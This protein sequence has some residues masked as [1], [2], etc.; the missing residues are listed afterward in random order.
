MADSPA[1]A[2]ESALG[3]EFSDPDLLVEALTHRSLSAEEPGE[4]SNERLEFLGD[5]VLGLVVAE[6]LHTR[7]ILSEGEMS[8][9][10]AGVVNESTLAAIATGLG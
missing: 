5:A 9:V 4:A 1:A 3:H 8:M 10:R 2:V 6:E 7:F